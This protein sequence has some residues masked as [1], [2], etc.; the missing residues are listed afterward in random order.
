MTHLSFLKK[1]P[2]VGNSGLVRGWHPT[3][4]V[5]CWFLVTIINIIRISISQPAIP[6]FFVA[7]FA[8]DSRNK[9]LEIVELMTVLPP[10]SLCSYSSC[11]FVYPMQTQ[12]GRQQFYTLC[13]YLFFVVGH[14]PRKKKFGPISGVPWVPPCSFKHCSELFSV[15]PWNCF[16]V[17]KHWNNTPQKRPLKI[18][19]D[20][21]WFTVKKNNIHI[22]RGFSQ[23][24]EV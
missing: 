14:G 16:P 13:I 21:S 6:F 9:G 17:V 22:F 8:V 19:H 20:T 10:D 18:L 23:L 2:L 7:H 4:A 3:H 24:F 15:T 5:M 11:C 12:R 1:G